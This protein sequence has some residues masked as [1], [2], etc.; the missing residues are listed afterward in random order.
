M[1]LSNPYA[2]HLKLIQNNIECKLKLKIRF[3]KMF[4]AVPHLCYE[5]T[6]GS[7]RKIKRREPENREQQLPSR[8]LTHLRDAWGHM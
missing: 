6:A 4:I 7:N 1:W 2:V 8:K 5:I 3:S